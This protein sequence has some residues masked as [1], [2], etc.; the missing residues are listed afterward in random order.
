MGE[1]VECFCIYLN[2]VCSN[3][4][5]GSFVVWGKYVVEIIMNYLLLMSFGEEFLLRKIY[6]LDGYVLLIG[7]GYD[8]NMF[9]YLF[10]V[11]FGVCELI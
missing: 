1:I 10:E 9:V 2:V 5:L 4:L 11:C 3:Y 7:V 6:D 8:F